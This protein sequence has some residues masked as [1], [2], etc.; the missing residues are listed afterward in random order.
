MIPD[1]TKTVIVVGDCSSST[2]TGGHESP[3]QHDVTY[4]HV[5][6]TPDTMVRWLPSNGDIS[7]VAWSKIGQGGA[8]LCLPELGKS[9]HGITLLIIVV[10]NRK[11]SRKKIQS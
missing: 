4:D 6:D 11:L 7:A 9:C 1:L 2:K 5:D 3:V 10:V 8:C